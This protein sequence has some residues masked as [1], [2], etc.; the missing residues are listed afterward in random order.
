M[1][2]RS[3][4]YEGSVGELE[5]SAYLATRLGR[6]PGVEGPG[7]FEVTAT[8]GMQVRV[9]AGA[10]SGFG[11]ADFSDAAESITI[12]SVASGTRYDAVVLRRDWAG[13]ST[14]PTG[15]ATQGRTYVAVVKGGAAQMIPAVQSIPGQL[16]DQL[17]AL[18]R[19]TAGQSTVT[20]SDDLRATHSSAAV[21]RSL[22]AMTGPLGTRY[23]LYPSGKRYY[24]AQTAAGTVAAV[25]E[26]EPS[27]P[28][29]PDVPRVRGGVASPVVFSATG[30]ATIVHNLGY[31]PP[32]FLAV[33]R[34]AASSPL[35]TIAL[36]AQAGATSTTSAIVTAKRPVTTGTGWEPY[37]GQITYV[38]WMAVG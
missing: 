25:E 9:A 16:A 22:L 7:D 11:I 15:S 34:L 17:L 26:W 29:L 1:T 6:P 3:V 12:E 38:D 21:V 23:A 32:V 5:W 36:S 10:A 8:S 2:I 37:A 35:V 28:T 4:G 31:D 30:A 24:M 19:V 14:T 18:V 33:P 27:A 13:T 20:V